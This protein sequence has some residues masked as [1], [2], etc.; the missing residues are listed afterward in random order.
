MSDTSI[1]SKEKL[2]YI[3]NKYNNIYLYIYIVIY[4]VIGLFVYFKFFS[5]SIDKKKQRK[6]DEYCDI[7]KN[8]SLFNH[9]VEFYGTG[10]SSDMD[11]CFLC[12][13]KNS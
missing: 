10:I 9:L 2:L 5:Q 11:Y 6:K 4:I 1:F 12:I 13:I 7:H 3:I 8:I